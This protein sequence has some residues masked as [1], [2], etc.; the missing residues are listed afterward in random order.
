MILTEDKL[1]TSIRGGNLARVYFL[2]GKEVFLTKT[3]SDRIVKKAV[4]AEPLDFNLIRLKGD[5]SP[6]A[7]GNSLESVP[8]FS[9]LKCV[10]INDFDPEKTDSDSLKKIID[11]ISDVPDY[12]IFIIEI[13]G[14]DID[15]K[16]AKTK[17]VISA[18]DKAGIV[19]EF[20][21]LTPAKVGELIIKKCA[22]TGC[23]ISREN[24]NYIAEL[25]LMNLTLVGEE[26]KK[27]CDYVGKGEITR[28]II[29]TL[30]TKQ[31]D[32]SI[33]ELATAITSGKRNLAFEILD[34][35]INQR[36]EPVVIMSALSGTFIDYYH[37][38]IGKNA[39]LA[40]N[41]TAE[42]FMYPK[43]RVWVINKA[44]TAAARLSLPYLRTCLS[45][46]DEADLRL[47]SSAASSRTIMEE[48][49]VK[50]MVA[51]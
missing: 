35:L 43:N 7:I 33:Y 2:Y 28:E 30:V 4:G 38:K 48:A 31:L 36:V 14:I 49:I 27:L 39:G 24:A 47:K 16:K 1:N 42:A 41:Q 13:T 17:K 6:E 26:T 37:A 25:T 32:T 34:D 12:S 9:E 18:A 3:Y 51:K 8:L 22:K 44:V 10:V 21:P 19:C 11:I 45:A 50:L 23:I 20:Q 29:D 46:L 5:S 15:P 40:P